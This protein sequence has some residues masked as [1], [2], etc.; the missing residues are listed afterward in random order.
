MSNGEIPIYL[1][2]TVDGNRTEFSIKRSIQESNWDP[3]RTKAKGKSKTSIELN[4][5]IDS[6]RN[7]K[8]SRI[9]KRIEL[10]GSS[11]YK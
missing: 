10:E 1:R 9:L 3:K 4:S 5:Y 7:S 6:I 2:I 8:L 11:N